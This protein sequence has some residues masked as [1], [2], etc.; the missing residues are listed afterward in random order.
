MLWEELNTPQ[1]EKAVS[2]SGGVCMLPIGVLEKHGS[3]LP[4]GTDMYTSR[5][6][7]RA[8]AC[9]AP[10]VVFP[11]YF[12][13][14]IAEARHYP[15]TVTLPHRLI[16]E[17]LLAICDEIRR[18]GFTKIMIMSG[19]GGNN[20]FLPFFCQEMP[21]LDRDYQ[22][23]SGFVARLTDEQRK[24]VTD[25][26]GETDLGQHAGL[27]ETALMMHICGNLVDMNAQNPSEGEPLG[28]LAETRKREMFT[29]FNWYADYP[30]HYAGDHTKATPQLGAMIFDMLVD[31]VTDDIRAVKADDESLQLVREY[32]CR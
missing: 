30:H 28:R 6:I 23:Y 27:A 9:E 17:N 16:M 24:K 4:L 7:C 32:K 10:A 19:H 12:M 31:N 1:F 3:H 21:R 8:A 25:A 20:H 11:Y 22:V 2:D 5:E 18:N 14:Q 26:A 29:G 13:G 15:G